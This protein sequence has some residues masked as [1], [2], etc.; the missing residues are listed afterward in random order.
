LSPGTISSIR[1]CRTTSV[2]VSTNCLGCTPG[3]GQSG[4][5]AVPRQ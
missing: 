3:D 4:Q 2:V 5:L 1:L